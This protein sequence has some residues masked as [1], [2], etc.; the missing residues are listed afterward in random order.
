MRYKLLYSSILAGL[1][2][3]FVISLGNGIWNRPLDYNDWNYRVFYGICHQLQDR[4]FHIN[5]IPMAVN[6]RCFG[7][8]S[9]LMAAWIMV[10]YLANLT[11]NK[12]WPGYLLSISVMVHIIDF[13]AGQL[14]IWNSS[15][16]S[17]FFLG[18]FLG[19]ALVCMIAD[20]FNKK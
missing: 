10:P 19:I 8:F 13:A 11:K 17:R 5:N 15:N 16:F 9:G 20:L 1:I 2:L 7:I 4:S 6:T 12:K 18:I 14:S 3:L